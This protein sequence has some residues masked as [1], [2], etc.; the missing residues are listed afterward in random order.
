MDCEILNCT[1]LTV[2]QTDKIVDSGYFIHLLGCVFN[3]PYV[4]VFKY[5]YKTV[6]SSEFLFN[7]IDFVGWYFDYFFFP[8]RCVG[9][10][11]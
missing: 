7:Q 9:I 3:A 4:Y 5:R 8:Q 6:F 11:F 1:H 2:F 10:L